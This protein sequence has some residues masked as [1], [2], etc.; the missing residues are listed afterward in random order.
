MRKLCEG[1]PGLSVSPLAFGGNMVF[2]RDLFSQVGFDTGITRGEDIDYLINARIAGFDFHF[3]PDLSILHRPPRHYDAP[4]YARLRQ[5]VIRFQ[6]EKYKVSKF[7]ISLENLMPYPGALM[8]EKFSTL[9]LEALKMVSTP[10]LDQIYGTPSE[11][12]GESMHE[13]ERKLDRYR[14]FVGNWSKA[15]ESI[16]NFNRG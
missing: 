15:I 9:A 13:N 4:L 6:Y 11:I 10:M 14:Q 5:D 16:T 2:H 3:D 8:T 12:I 1:A 7:G